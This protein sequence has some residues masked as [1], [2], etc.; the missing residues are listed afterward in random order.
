MPFVNAM[1]SFL[2]RRHALAKH[3]SSTTSAD[4]A[5]FRAKHRGINQV[6]SWSG[7]SSQ[8]AIQDPYSV[9]FGPPPNMPK[10]MHCHCEIRNRTQTRAGVCQWQVETEADRA[11]IH[12]RLLMQ[13]VSLRIGEFPLQHIG[14]GRPF[15][16]A[17]VAW[18]SQSTEVMTS[19]ARPGAIAAKNEQNETEGRQGFHAMLH[20]RVNL[21]SSTQKRK[22]MKCDLLPSPCSTMTPK[23]PL[24]VLPTPPPKLPPPNP[25]LPRK[26]PPPL[27][28]FL[29]DPFLLWAERLATSM[30]ATNVPR[31][32]L[33][34]YFR[35]TSA[36][37][38][39]GRKNRIPKREGPKSCQQHPMA[40]PAR[41][42]GFHHWPVVRSRR[43]HFEFP[44]RKRRDHQ[45]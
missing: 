38:R 37:I 27:L 12:Q 4:L 17:N 8:P 21:T 25:P 31:L 28:K 2:P 20:V 13:D 5:D 9:P 22:S 6:R 32:L 14:R 44:M 42:P 24:L 26:P 1:H 34:A 45:P 11:R 18:S 35:T 41:I 33:R 30:N 19:W 29:K 15:V 3:A 23:R 39:I 43:G 40:R 7:P 10:D 36:R 16:R